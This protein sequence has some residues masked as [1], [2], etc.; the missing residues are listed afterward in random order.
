MMA[1]FVG[2]LVVGNASCMEPEL[3]LLMAV[4]HYMKTFVGE[5]IFKVALP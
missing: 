2:I 3:H 1:T 4:Y 5:G